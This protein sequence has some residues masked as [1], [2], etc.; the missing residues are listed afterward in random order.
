[1]CVSY[2]RGINLPADQWGAL[3]AHKEQV[4]HALGMGL[5]RSSTSQVNL[6]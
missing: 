2:V 6:N 5:V 4:D 3:C 1:M